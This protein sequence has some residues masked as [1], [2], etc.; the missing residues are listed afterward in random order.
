MRERRV[1]SIATWVTPVLCMAVRYPVPTRMQDRIVR[2]SEAPLAPA[3]PPRLSHRKRTPLFDDDDVAS[4][5]RELDAPRVRGAELVEAE[6]NAARQRL[7]NEKDL[8]AIRVFGE[9]ARGCERM[10]HVRAVLE[11]E[12]ARVLHL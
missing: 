11:L 4:L 9:P 8:V 1:S 10:K 6:A 12:D 3:S 7:P 5:Q 2:S